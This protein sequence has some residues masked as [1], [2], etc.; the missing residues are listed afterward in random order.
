MYNQYNQYNR[1]GQYQGPTTLGISERWERV[2]CYAGVWV[3]GLIF[4]LIEQRNQTV[5][6]HAAQSVVVFGALSLLGII[7]GWL[8]GIWVIGFIFGLIASL[9]GAV[10]FALWILLMVLAYFSPNTF[11]SGPRFTRFF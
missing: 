6:R 10:S 7:A 5:R 11:I 9:I 1:P 8:S 2:L 3:T 4:L